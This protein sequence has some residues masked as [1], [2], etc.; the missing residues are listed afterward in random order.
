MKRFKL[1]ERFIFPSLLLV[2]SF[3]L[4]VVYA[5]QAAEKITVTGKVTDEKNLP[6]ANATVKVAGET[7]S[8]MT[9]ENGTF[10][11]AVKKNGT[12]LFSYVGYGE[13][14]INVQ[15]NLVHD[16]QF[17]PASRDLNAVTVI[18]YGTQKSKNVTGAVG[19]IGSKEIKQVAV[20][21]LDQAL[22][23]RV[24]GVQ[25]AENSA[26]PG[27][28]V[29]VRIRGVAS[30]TSGSDPLVVVDGVPMSVSL[31]SINPNDIE[32]IDVLKD[33]ASAAIYGSRG[34]AGVI[35]VTTKRG[36]SGKLRINLDAY[37]SSQFVTKRISLLNGP[38]FAKL[39]NENLLNG[40]QTP[41]PEWIN[42]EN[43]VSTNWQDEI[44]RAAPMHNYN[45]SISG[46]SEKSKN[47]LSFGYTSQ[48]GVLSS[49]ATYKRFTARY[50]ADYDISDRIKIGV[51]VNYN[52]DQKSGIRTQDDNTGTIISILQAQ[53]TNPVF[54]DKT[55]AFGDHLF[56]FEG[57]AFSTRQNLYYAGIGNN[58]VYVAN[59]HFFSKGN[60][61]QLLANAFGEVEL[62]PGLKIKSMIAYTI[63]NGTGSNG[64]NKVP[65]AASNGGGGLNDRTAIGSSFNQSKQWNWVN[66]LSYNNSFGKHNVS[67]VAGTDALK[68][69]GSYLSVNAYGAPVNQNSITASSDLSGRPRGNPFIPASLV[70][71]FARV[72]YNYDSRYLVS[73]TFRRDGSSKFG[74]FQTWGN[75]PSV[76][77][78]WRLSKE[79]FMESV[80]FVDEL[81]LRG[82]YGAVG[83]QNIPDLQYYTQYGTAG[84][85]YAYALNGVLIPGLRP[86]VLGNDSI[87]WERN[88]ERNFGLD[89]SLLKGKITF[90]IDVYKKQLKDLLGDVP[91]PY[92]AAP[93]SG[94]VLKNA[95]S[96]ENSG[97]ELN[98]GLNQ[99][100]GKV[101]LSFNAN[102]STLKNKITALTP[103]DN[104]SYVFQN[105]SNISEMK[106]T[107]RSEVGERIANFWG[108]VTDGIIQNAVEAKKYQDMGFKFAEPGDRKYK[109]LNGDG[110]L[111]DDD[112]KIIG[113][114]LPGY[115]FGFNLRVEYKGFDV[116][117]FFNGQGDVQVANMTRYFTSSIN[118][119]NP[120][121]VNGSTDI[122]NSW[123]G[124]G[125]SN[126][127]PRNSLKAIQSNKWFND[128]YIENGAFVRLRNIQ[129]GYTL[130]AKILARFGA[131]NARFYIAGQ[132][133][134][135]F[136]SYSGYD[137]EVG[138]SR[139]T[140]G[141][142]VQTSGVDYGRYPMA[143]MV[144]FGFTAQF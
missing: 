140:G 44:F 99:K 91:V 26:E 24:A 125:T 30:I 55:G 15:G 2:F 141:S 116:N 1:K 109:D 75:F 34:S 4:P 136:S 124:E 50:N 7:T 113:N 93:F 135:T 53:P 92:Y 114:G 120:G 10:S 20:V 132:N 37:T 117:L 71:Y 104:K 61:N 134:L 96:M 62:I 18:G 67:A 144:T 70:S 127:L 23:G 33:A 79:N 27:A 74:P 41:N 131:D 106:A 126:T 56:G 115:L 21:S 102:F 105:I 46:G 73:G 85:N 80:S 128:S 121:M 22:Q 12:L 5:Q 31:S 68:F 111:N 94:K 84:G 16:I 108:F 6:L 133:L 25:V 89:A 51:N 107:T 122:L 139:A 8:V 32:T 14:E 98:L 101:N 110:K 52:T 90:S 36:K 54:T 112:R 118:F 77:V 100:V 66:T 49:A 59:K 47:Y 97:I 143:K 129:V 38:Q 78:G 123:K 58:P 69:N 88:V 43:V 95:F 81:K 137:P 138:S 142:G 130:P 45:V 87:H 76:S 13:Q 119:R 103:G 42:P 82:S 63:S 35:L 19:R 83:N 11:I 60:G 65:T 86:T 39:A 3:L 17:S 48:D 9:K 72:N 28:D 57:Y 29:S 40:G 64:N